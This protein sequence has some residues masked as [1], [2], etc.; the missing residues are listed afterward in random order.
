MVNVMV[1][2][3]DRG[4]AELTIDPVNGAPQQWSPDAQA[5]D[6][7]IDPNTDADGWGS[8]DPV[9]NPDDTMAI[10]F[11]AWERS[12]AD[13]AGNYGRAIEHSTISSRR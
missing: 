4:W 3:G 2:G 10:G 12:F 7:D 9:A 13:Q 1:E 8:F 11:A 5:D 6:S